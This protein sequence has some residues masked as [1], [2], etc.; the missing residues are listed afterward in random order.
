[1]R[2]LGHGG[3]PLCTFTPGTTGR[4]RLEGIV[5]E[6]AIDTFAAPFGSVYLN[7]Q[8]GCVP[9]GAEI[10]MRIREPAR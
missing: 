3:S 6:N 5:F 7:D 10:V 4:I 8:T 9:F 1:L 2:K